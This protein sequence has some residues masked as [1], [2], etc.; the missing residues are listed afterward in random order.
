M[1]HAA[2]II[3][4]STNADADRIFLR[5]VLGLG[6]VDAGGG[7]L[8]FKLPPAEIAVHPTEG[9]S[10]HEFYF[11][12]ED[13]ERT[14]ADLTAKGVKISRTISNQ[15]WGKLAA[16]KLPSGADLPIY[17]PLHPTAFDLEG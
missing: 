12:C 9:V 3:L 1:L 16:I 17:Q 5:D 15:G 11:M 10:T 6:S 2:H 14:L 8:I 13:I 4:Y 7:W